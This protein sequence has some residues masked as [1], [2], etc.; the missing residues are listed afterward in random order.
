MLQDGFAER[1]AER[2][3]ALRPAERRVADHFLELGPQAALQSA[4]AVAAHVG[5][6]DATVVRTAKALGY[7]GLSDLREALAARSTEPAPQERLRRTLDHMG[8]DDVLGAT[9]RDH[10][11]GLD[12]MSRRI[13]SRDFQR[14][15]AVLTASARVVWRGVGPSSHLARYAA[16]L[17]QRIGKP[18]TTL[19]GTGASFAD[20]LLSL[21]RGDAAVVFA[22]G[23][24]QPHVGVLL[25]HAA[26]LDIP[27]VLV[28]DAL[29]RRYS[30]KAHTT[31][32][33]GRGRPGLF[34]SHGTTTVLIEALVLAVAS[35]DRPRAEASL[36]TLNG[37]RAALIGRRAD[38]DAT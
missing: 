35:T 13:D 18:T 21:T 19:V 3:G 22:Y 28:T 4:A 10:V 36:A 23:R 17:T 2:R 15:V 9:I 31:L 25:D 6:S 5:T 34:A 12:E 27:V 26:G 24:P 11:V 1:V 37:L 8:P 20:E 29:G 16:V 30:A 7:R 33:A 38:V 32:A 14:A